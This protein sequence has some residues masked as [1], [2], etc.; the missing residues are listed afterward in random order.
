MKKIIVIGGLGFIGFNM[1]LHLI[2][3]KKYKVYI[4]DCLSGVSSKKNLN[5]MKKNNIKVPIFKLNIRD[6]E[7]TLKVIKKIKPFTIFLLSGQVAVTKSIKNP[8]KDFEDNLLSTFNI[9]E[10]IRNLNN[11]I[12]LVTV[13]SNKGLWRPKKFTN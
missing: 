2:N 1:V 12:N 13:S 3:K 7:K 5:Y 8:K 6:Y 9:L 4:I 11:K 10:I